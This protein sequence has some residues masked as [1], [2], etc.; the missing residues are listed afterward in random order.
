MSALHS[1]IE[2]TWL[3]TLPLSDGSDEAAKDTSLS[4]Q[5]LCHE[6]MQCSMGGVCVRPVHIQEAALALGQSTVRL[7]SV[8]G[9]PKQKTPIANAIATGWGQAPLAEK[10]A[11]AE[12]AIHFGAQEIDWVINTAVFAQEWQNAANQPANWLQTKAEWQTA[13]AAVFPHPLKL[14]LETSL[15]SAKQIES[16]CQLASTLVAENPQGKLF[17]KTCTGYLTDCTGATPEVIALIQEALGDFYPDCIGIK[18]SG[19]IK[20]HAQA[21]A[22]LAAGATRLGTSSGVSL[23]KANVVESCLSISSDDKRAATY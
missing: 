22:L 17:I 23:L 20:T 9:F 10:L 16:L 18:A 15:W 1:A 6:A 2:H 4:I 13:R 5:Q 21:M 11:D 12:A 14:I 19:G 8:A 3:P 7:V